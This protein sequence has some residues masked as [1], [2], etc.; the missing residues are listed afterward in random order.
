MSGNGVRFSERELIPSGQPQTSRLSRPTVD[1]GAS[2]G[3]PPAARP[4]VP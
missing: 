4:E 2:G 3:Q 1:A